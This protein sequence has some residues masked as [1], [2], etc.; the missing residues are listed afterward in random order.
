MS[1]GLKKI[2]DLN[3]KKNKK[4][5]IFITREMLWYKNVIFLS[6]FK[7]LKTMWRKNE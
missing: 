3:E 5:H 1:F 2:F 7:K 4:S 6:R